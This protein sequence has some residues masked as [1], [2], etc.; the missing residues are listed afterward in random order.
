MGKWSQQKFETVEEMKGRRKR[1]MKNEGTR[2][3]MMNDLDL[4]TI[5]VRDTEGEEISRKFLL[6]HFFFL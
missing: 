2:E 4:N 1:R 3:G 5:V 6:L